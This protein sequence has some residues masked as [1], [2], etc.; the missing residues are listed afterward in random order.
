MTRN[1]A[2]KLALLLL[3]ITL[4]IAGF[5]GTSRGVYFGNLGVLLV[6]QKGP[7]PYPPAATSITY[8]GLAA[9]YTTVLFGPVTRDPAP[10]T[11]LVLPATVKILKIEYLA[12]ATLVGLFEGFVTVKL[13]TVSVLNDPPWVTQPPCH[14]AAEDTEGL[15]GLTPGAFELERV[16]N[17]LPPRALPLGA[18]QPSPSSLPAKISLG[19]LP[20]VG[21][22]GTLAHLGSPGSCISW[23]FAYG[24]GSYTAAR[25]PDGSVRWDPAQP[26]NQVSP[27]FMYALVHAEEGKT[28][29]SGSGEGYLTQLVAAGAPSVKDVPYA[30]DCC[31]INAIDVEQTFPKEDRFRIGSFAKIPLP[32][33]PSSGADPAATL[34]L[35][36][37]FLAAG[38]AVAFAGPV[39][40]GFSALP[41]SQGVYYPTSWCTATPTTPCGHGMLLVGYDDTIGDPAKGKGAF[42]VQNSFGVNWPPASSQSPAPP[43]RFYLAYSAF[44][45]AQLSAQV[46]YPLDQR[47]TSAPSLASSPAGGPSAFVTTGHQWI[48]GTSAYLILQHRFSQPVELVSVTLAEPA[49][50]TGRVT[51]VNGYPM[52]N[53]YTY[54]VRSDGNS[55]LPG[56]Y[57]VT[58]V[59]KD[60]SDAT[61]TYTGSIAIPKLSKLGP[62]LPAATM[63]AEV[64]DSAGQ[65]VFVDH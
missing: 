27:A 53:G 16:A 38:H 23:S 52:A 10:E 34:S 17:A 13:G 56:T 11:A 31:Y 57:A 1:H 22:Q 8:T 35:L 46:A 40:T 45:A 54:L 64:I 41:L 63:P 49:P 25:N 12:D 20:P 50:A 37:Q 60:A 36:K 42:L 44:L 62:K 15:F 32:A 26:K 7:R 48:D 24:L 4:A 29:P 3:S 9:D 14:T 30:P 55:F 58:I 21:F 28:C 5:P 33:A 51:Q 18:L 61:F 19:N 65:V 6:V 2:T 59:A 39:Y 47:P 43:G